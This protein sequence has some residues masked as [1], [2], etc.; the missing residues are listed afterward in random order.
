MHLKDPS[1]AALGNMRLEAQGSDVSAGPTPKTV[2]DAL[3]L[4]ESLREPIAKELEGIDGEGLPISLDAMGVLQ[5]EKGGMAHVLW[6]GPKHSRIPTP[7]DKVASM[8]AFHLPT[9]DS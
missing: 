1:K 7:L 2:A 9:I 4:L 8:S 3:A 5:T 6:I